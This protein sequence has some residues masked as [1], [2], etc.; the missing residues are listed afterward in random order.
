MG[1]TRRGAL[2]ARVAFVPP[3]DRR[4]SASTELLL[5]RRLAKPLEVAFLIDRLSKNITGLLRL[6]LILLDSILLRLL[7][8]CIKGCLSLG[9]RHLYGGEQYLNLLGGKMPKMPSML[10]GITL[11]Q[12]LMTLVN[13]WI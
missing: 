2:R 9:L 13:A 8:P 1:W 3:L 4:L 10:L 5:D 11:S 7:D 6:L 12:S